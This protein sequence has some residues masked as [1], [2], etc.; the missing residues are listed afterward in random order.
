[1]IERNK[2]QV[3]EI[4]KRKTT[5]WSSYK[6]VIKCISTSGMIHLQVKKL[7][8]K[9]KYQRWCKFVLKLLYYILL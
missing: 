5:H 1:M 8:K 7:Q 6:G 2:I 4:G 3:N 9:S